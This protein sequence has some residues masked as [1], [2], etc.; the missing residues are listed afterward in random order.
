MNLVQLANTQ[1]LAVVADSDIYE[2]PDAA[3]QDQAIRYAAWDAAKP[4]KALVYAGVHEQRSVYV[5]L[6]RAV[7]DPLDPPAVVPTRE[8]DA[9]T[10]RLS[11]AEKRKAARLARLER[12]A[13]RPSRFE[14]IPKEHNGV[15]YGA[16]QK[17]LIRTSTHALTW[18]PGRSC[19][20]GR[21]SGNDYI[22]G[23]FCV[24]E[25]QAAPGHQHGL[26]YVVKYR[27]GVT[28]DITPPGFRFS[29]KNVLALLPAIAKALAIPEAALAGWKVDTTL[30]ITT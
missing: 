25:I 22:P 5:V 15:D 20:T 7:Y 21:G 17:V 26:G 14:I 4:R 27:N 29:A 8:T 18:L 10:A 16:P 1:L 13:E 23:E 24:R 6:S 28:K 19:W 9:E 11:E 3:V 12:A 30:V 2:R